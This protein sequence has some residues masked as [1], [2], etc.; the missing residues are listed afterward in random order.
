MPL[1]LAQ[2]AR[3]GKKP[4]TGTIKPPSPWID[5][6]KITATTS[7]PSCY[8]VIVIARRAASCPI[9]LVSSR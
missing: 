3:A 2:S 7:V 6:I 8:S 4:S 9:S 1:F 5:S